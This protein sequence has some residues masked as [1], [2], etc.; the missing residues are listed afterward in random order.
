MKKSIV[1]LIAV[2]G[3]AAFIPQDLSA[4]VGIKGGY[5]LSKLPMKSPD[6]LP[7][8]FGN[9]PF[10]TGGLYFNLGLGFVSIQPEILYVRNGGHYELDPDNYLE[11]RFE[12]VQVPVLLKFNVVPAG[13][14]RPFLCAGAYGAYLFKATGV[15]VEAGTELPRADLSDDYQRI[16]YGVVGGAGLTFKLPGIALTVEGRYNYG[17]RNLL[18]DP[19]AG[20]S[21]KN[22]SLM[23]LVG[24]GF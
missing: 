1:V 16:D 17:L 11:F 14:I 7:F 20:E 13:P 8:E 4:G 12:Y 6:P 2:I 15:I 9:L 5:T 18:I 19:A 23:A 10:F 22:S 3:L 24:I 21:M